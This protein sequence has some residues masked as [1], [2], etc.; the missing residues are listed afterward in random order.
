MAKALIYRTA[1]LGAIVLIVLVLCIIALAWSEIVAAAQTAWAIF[2]FL[3]LILACVKL[4]PG[5]IM[6][7]HREKYA[8]R[9][10]KRLEQDL[11]VERIFGGQWI[12]AR[13]HNNDDGRGTSLVWLPDEEE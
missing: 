7:R 5:Y 8:E 13:S 11:A 2:I 12:H 10:T 6:A 1:E 4:V 9:A 3:V